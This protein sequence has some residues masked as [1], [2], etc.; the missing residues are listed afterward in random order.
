MTEA[1]LKQFIAR[2]VEARMTPLLS[3]VQQL[4]EQVEQVADAGR[5]VVKPV[6]RQLERIDG[7]ISR[8]LAQMRKDAEHRD[9]TLNALLLQMASI[10]RLLGIDP[11]ERTI[12][13]NYQN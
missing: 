2:E 8:Q 11:A 6:K 4:L 5:G 3:A 7:K 12:D 10:H 9:R 1:E 13:P